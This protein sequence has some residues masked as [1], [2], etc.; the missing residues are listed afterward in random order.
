MFAFLIFFVLPLVISTKVATNRG[1]SW[2]WGFFP[3]LVLGW[4]GCILTLIFL[5]KKK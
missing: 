4:I 3:A 2:A 1:Q 5:T